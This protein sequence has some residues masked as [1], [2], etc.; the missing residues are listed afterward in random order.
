MTANYTD[1]V[2]RRF[3]AEGFDHLERLR[4]KCAKNLELGDFLEAEW[5]ANDITM[6]WIEHESTFKENQYQFLDRQAQ[7]RVVLDRIEARLVGLENGPLGRWAGE[8]TVRER[9][10]LGQLRTGWENDEFEPVFEAELG[11][12]EAFQRALQA[13]ED[14]EHAFQER[15][16]IAQ[17]IQETLIALSLI[18]I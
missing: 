5:T 8:C 16:V 3:D 6:A 15:L 18:H 14:R 4:Q 9:A 10:R 17:G 13:A 12:A 7:A 1:D 2:R 11:F